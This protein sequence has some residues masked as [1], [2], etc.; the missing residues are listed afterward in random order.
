VPPYEYDVFHD[1]FEFMYSTFTF[2][3]LLA[4]QG[5]PPTPE[6][7]IQWEGSNPDVQTKPHA[8]RDHSEYIKTQVRAIDERT[9]VVSDEAETES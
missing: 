8:P 2:A 5:V 9:G 3:D 4:M 6:N 7:V 1:T